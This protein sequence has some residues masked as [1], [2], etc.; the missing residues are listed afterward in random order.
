MAPET[1]LLI[2]GSLPSAASLASGR[3]YAHP[4]NQFWSLLGDVLETDL[5][6]LGYSERLERLK[7]AGIGL[8]DAL[9]G[10]YRN[11]SSDAAISRPVVRTMREAEFSLPELRCVAFNG[12]VAAS[13]GA[14]LSESRPVQLLTLPSSSA[15]ATAAYPVKL[16]A[17][18]TVRAH[19]KQQAGRCEEPDKAEPTAGS[20]LP[21]S[22][23]CGTHNEQ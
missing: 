18:L 2:L 9:A 4:A 17:W 1:R 15:R 14:R 23:T 6:G 8:S 5:A 13:H 10:A 22:W 11:S 3:Y 7:L 19:L 21:F 16:R 20:G 12:L